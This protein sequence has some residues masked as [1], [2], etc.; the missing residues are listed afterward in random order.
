MTEAA[1]QREI[2]AFVRQL[3]FAVY[4]TSQGYRRDPGGTRCTA[5]IPDLY[6]IGHGFHLWVEVKAPKGKL[7][8]SQEAF[9]VECLRNG[10]PWELWRDVRD[11]WDWG[12]RMGVVREA[13]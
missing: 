1:I 6:I 9:R 11:A 12:V 10:V 4:E 13:A 2:V 5:G 7:R 3:G 8:P